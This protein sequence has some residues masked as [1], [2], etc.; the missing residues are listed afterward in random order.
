MAASGTVPGR[1]LNQFSLDEEDGFLRIATTTGWGRDASN[2]VFVMEQEAD[3]LEVVGS[4]KDIAPTE[5]IQA[6]RFLGDVG[7]VVTFERVDPLF[8][9]DLSNP[10]QPRLVGEL[11]IP[12]FS[13]YLQPL[14][15]NHLIGL[16]RNADEIT[17]QVLGLQLSL[18]DVSDLANP[19][20]TGL[21][22]F[23][24][25][26]WGGY[27]EAEHDF[28]AFSLF[29]DQGILALPVQVGNWWNWQPAGLQVFR[30]GIASGFEF[31][32]EIQHTQEIRRS[33]R[34]GD[35]LYSYSANEIQVHVLDKPQQQVAKLQISEGQ[36]DPVWYAL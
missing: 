20:R 18:F 3:S 35:Y 2:H 10:Y 25:E 24:G 27:S 26:G 36:P 13:S 14:G 33:F 12:G 22:Q 31:L 29:P 34:I 11:E 5:T 7:F 4:V 19:R 16:G 9:L 6:V 28:K 32:G 1:I 8:T 23:P 15:D 17:G 30:V 21:Y